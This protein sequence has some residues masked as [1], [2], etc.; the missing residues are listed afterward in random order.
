MI[1][2]AKTVAK[3]RVAAAVATMGAKARTPVP[4]KADA[5]PKGAANPEPSRGLR[6]VTSSWRLKRM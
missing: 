2:R 6:F 1:A 4:E 3:G 5:T